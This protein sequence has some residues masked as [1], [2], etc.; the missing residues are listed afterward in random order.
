M[1]A[2]S[3]ANLPV[4]AVLGLALAVAACAGVGSNLVSGPTMSGDASGGNAAGQGTLA[5]VGTWRA[6][7]LAP[8]GEAEVVLGEPGRFTAEFRADGG[9]ALR[10]DCNRCSAIYSARL[11]WLSTSPMACTLAACPS[12]PRDTQFAGLVSAATSWTVAGDHLELASTAG[13]V[14][15]QR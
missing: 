12:A 2:R 15:L 6:L 3:M 5:L 7:S 9:L 14:R 4:V 11:G 8:A 13:V 10:A 1:R